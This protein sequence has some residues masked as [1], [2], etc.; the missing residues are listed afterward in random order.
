MIKINKNLFVFSGLIFLLG[1]SSLVFLQ[2]FLP[3]VSHTAYY[4][5][6]FIN[7]LSLPIPY[8]LGAIPFLLFSIFFCIAIIKLSVIYIKVRFLRKNL[9]R[10]LKSNISFTL[11]LKKLGLDYKTY[12]IENE[13][14]FAFCLG[15]LHP[16]IYISTSLIKILKIKELEA[17]LRHERYH[18]DNRDTITMLIASIGESLLPFFPLLSD[19]LQNYRIER[20][21]RADAEAILGQGGERHLISVLKKL[22]STPS[23]ALATTAAIADHDTLEPRINALIKKDFRFRQFKVKHIFISLVSVFVMSVITLTPVHAV[24]VHHMGKDVMMICPQNDECLNSCKKE[25]SIQ[26]KNYS[27]NMLYTP[28]K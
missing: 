27:E 5:Q 1:I 3:L 20:E 8:Y 26:R 15:I 14:H 24:E 19:I 23:L 28:T 16:K 21:I 13:K 11:L 17:V 9:I 6:S 2:K 18:L 10:N 4:C 12:L 25:Y 22:L 7:S